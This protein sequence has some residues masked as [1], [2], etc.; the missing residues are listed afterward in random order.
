M[1]KRLRLLFV[2]F[3]VSFAIMAALSLFAI[4]QFTSLIAYSNQVD[5]TNKVITQLY[6]IEGLIQE[7]EVKERGYLIS[8]DSSDM[9]GL[10]ELIS[11][12]I[13]AADTLKVLISDDN[14]QKTNLIYL[15]SL[16]TERKDY[17]KENLL[18]VDTALNKALSPAFLKGIAIRQQLKD[19]L[20]SMREREFAYLEDKFRTKT[21]Y[22]Q[23]TNSTI[24]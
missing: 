3:S 16:L 19:R 17:M 2:A 22:Q 8:R 12:I 18:Y 11:N 14:S 10:F 15:K 6:Y 4:R 9:A 20:S 5:H 23:I 24:R 13:P 1:K 21:Y 7:T